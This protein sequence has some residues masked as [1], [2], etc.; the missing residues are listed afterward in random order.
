MDRRAEQN[1]PTPPLPCSL[2]PW[3]ASGI[4]PSDASPREGWLFN[5]PEGQHSDHPDRQW[6]KLLTPRMVSP[7]GGR[8]LEGPGGQASGMGDFPI[9]SIRNCRTAGSSSRQVSRPPTVL[10]LGWS[11]F[12]PAGGQEVEQS[13]SPAGPPSRSRAIL[14]SRSLK[15]GGSGPRAF[16]Q[17][18]PSATLTAE[19]SDFEIA[20]LGTTP[21]PR[22]PDTQVF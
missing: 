18:G 11:A 22:W 21:L 9:A 15:I 3:A 6:P 17:S 20:E 7:Q 5:H 1:R 2:K 8:M 10:V 4:F 13:Y 14:H 16:L 19:E 12:G